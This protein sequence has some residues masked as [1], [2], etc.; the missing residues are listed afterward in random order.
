[1]RILERNP[2]S[3]TISVVLRAGGLELMT[4]SHETPFACMGTNLPVGVAD[5]WNL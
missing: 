1:M 2:D 5:S 3:S 4:R